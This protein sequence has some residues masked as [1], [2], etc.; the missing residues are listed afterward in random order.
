MKAK[1]VSE[2][3]NEGKFGRG[4]AGAALGTA[5]AFGSPQVGQAAEPA[6]TEQSQVA[7]ENLP[8]RVKEILAK[9]EA[10]GYKQLRVKDSPVSPEL[11]KDL[12]VDWT[13]VYT[14]TFDQK[15]NMEDAYNLKKIVMEFMPFEPETSARGN[16]QWTGSKVD[17]KI[18]DVASDGN[19][20]LR[21]DIK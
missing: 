5:L 18:Q 11:A 8:P 6:S 2:E 20:A 7:E 16:M 1:L 17:I 14:V 4:L 9:A 21:F 19:T 10:A 12:G 13:R 3:L 15:W